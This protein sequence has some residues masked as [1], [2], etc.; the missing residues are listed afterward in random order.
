M[1]AAKVASGIVTEVVASVRPAI[2]RD[3]KAAIYV[4][5][6]PSWIRQV[7]AADTKAIR[8]CREPVGGEPG[9]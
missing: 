9:G 7:R 8:E 4:D 3:R 2:L 5:R 6:S 1:S